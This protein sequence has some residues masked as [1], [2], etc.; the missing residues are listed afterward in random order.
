[1]T[2]AE[3]GR[4]IYISEGCISCHS[5]YV[6]P[7]SPDVVM[8]GPT[9]SL[10]ELHAQKP[11]LIGNRRQ[12]PDLSQVGM[13]RSSLW[14]KAHL[15]NPAEISYRSPMPSF[16][17]LFGDTRG[18]DLVEYLSSLH[19][20]GVKQQLQ[21]E[22]SWFP[23]PAAST[24]ANAHEGRLVYDQHCATCHDSR[25]AIRL[26]WLST[27]HVIPQTLP[28]LQRYSA[29]QSSPKLAQITKFGIPGTDMPGH[30]Y[31]SDKQIASVAVFLKSAQMH[32]VS[33]PSPQLTGDHK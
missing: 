4:Q 21:R 2:P 12:G 19:G 6:R 10:E 15:I 31:L 18:E 28:E 27:W 11:P 1:M 14:L 9:E 8:W 33:Q 13:R 20:A 7:D 25:G 26:H 16:A 22:Q 23:A 29:D 5:Q 30:E 3:R 32:A 17:F 24:S